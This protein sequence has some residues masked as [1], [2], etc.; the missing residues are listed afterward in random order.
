MKSIFLAAALIVSAI[1]SCTRDSVIC[2]HEKAEVK[3]SS[4]IINTKPQA[5]AVD[6]I[7]SPTDSIGVYMYSENATNIVEGKANIQY[8]TENGGNIGDFKAKGEVIYFPD[9]WDK[10]RFMAYYPYMPEVS[11]D[12]VYKVDVSNQLNQ[13]AIDLLYSFDTD[14]VYDKSAINKKVS[15]VFD[16]KL[17]KIIV[18]VKAGTGVVNTDLD[19]LTISISELNTKANFNLENGTLSDYSNVAKITPLATIPQNDYAKGF[20]AIILPETSIPNAEIVFNLNNGDP[21]NSSLYTWKFDNVLN[22]ATKY[23]YNV[24]IN[25]SGIVVEATINDWINGGEN[26]INAE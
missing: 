14:A 25:R 5:R 3:F 10:V 24:T 22:A 4:N 8:V 16:H 6:D 19:N 15:L 1:V 12:Y 13:P 11:T 23:T 26:D 2:V 17:T 7:W 18:N 9:N 20:E 21:E